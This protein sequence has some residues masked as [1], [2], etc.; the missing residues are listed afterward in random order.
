MGPSLGVPQSGESNANSA[1]ATGKQAYVPQPRMNSGLAFK[2]GK[3]Y[4][5]GGI[6]E[7][8]DKQLTLSDLH[9]LGEYI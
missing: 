9:S 6:Y 3:L 7:V 1:V 5:Y 4:L 2:Q 8:G